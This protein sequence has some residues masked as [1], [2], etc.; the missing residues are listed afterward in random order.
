GAWRERSTTVV[1]TGDLD[2]W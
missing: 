1:A 2:Y